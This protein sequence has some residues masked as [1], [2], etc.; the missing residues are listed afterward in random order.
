M[1]TLNE[2]IMN[3]RSNS[4]SVFSSSKGPNVASNPNELKH[5][6]QSDLAASMPGTQRH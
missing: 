5:A 2:A 1:P 4:I 3:S 6:F